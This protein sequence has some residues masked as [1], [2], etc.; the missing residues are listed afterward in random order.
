MS[1][2]RKPKTVRL[3]R[4]KAIERLDAMAHAVCEEADF[5]ARVNAAFEGGN[6]AIHQFK[7]EHG[8]SPAFS[9]AQCMNTLQTAALFTIASTLGRLFDP[10]S[11]TRHPNERDV[12]SIPLVLHLLRQKRCQ[13]ELAERARHWLFEMPEMAEINAETVLTA[14]DEAIEAYASLRRSPKGQ[15]ALR[16]LMRFRHDH[17]AHRLL[18][19]LQRGQLRDTYTTVG[20]IWR[21]LDTALILA[22]KLSLAVSGD[23]RDA[24]DM[25]HARHREAR[26]VWDYLMT[27]KP[28]CASASFVP[29]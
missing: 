3:T 7:I 9:G 29:D 21:L 8:R 24:R 17:L 5:A 19:D 11:A 16:V 4:A 13:D 2:R 25:H 28:E 18:P 6:D 14:A 20:E 1:K 27:D 12:A 10:G 15:R 22:D 26:A 23:G